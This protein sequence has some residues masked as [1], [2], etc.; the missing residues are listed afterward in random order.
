MVILDHS[1]TILTRKNFR[2]FFDFFWSFLTIFGPKKSNFLGRNFEI[3]FHPLKKDLYCG[4][5]ALLHASLR[6]LKS[7][8]SLDLSNFDPKYCK[9]YWKLKATI[10][11]PEGVM[12]TGKT[13]HQFWPKTRHDIILPLPSFQLNYVVNSLRFELLIRYLRSDTPPKSTN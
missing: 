3:F 5:F 10:N 7:A 12:F 1:K 4:H 6:P 13:G 8:G 2:K 11:W 9:S